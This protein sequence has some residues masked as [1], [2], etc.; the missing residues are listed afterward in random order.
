[1]NVQFYE[2]NTFYKTHSRIW[3]GMVFFC[4]MF[5][6][7][8]QVSPQILPN[9]QATLSPLIEPVIGYIGSIL[10]GSE[11]ENTKLLSDTKA[12]YTFLSVLLLVSIVT[13]LSINKKWLLK[14]STKS[15]YWLIVIFRYYLAYQ[16]FHY[17][18]NKLF[19]WQFFLP[20]PN[21]VYSELGQITPD[22]LYWSAVGSSYGYTVFAGS[23]EIATALLLLFKRTYKIGALAAIVIFSNV[24]LVNFTFNI[25]VKVF[26]SFLLVLSIL[27]FSPS[28]KPLVNLLTFKA[29]EQPTFN[30]TTTNVNPWVYRATK[31]IV[32]LLF[33]AD[34]LWIY[35]KSKNWNDDQFPRISIHGAYEVITS[36]NTDIQ[37]VFINRKGYLVMEDLETNRTDF[38]ISVD[39][40]SR[41]FEMH[42][43]DSTSIWMYEWSED[44][45]LLLKS[46]KPLQ[47]YKLRK[48]PYRNL[49]IFKDTFNWWID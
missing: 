25:S 24:V 41:V 3:I 44:K 27:L 48:L 36:S 11:L 8:F 42:R 30:K 28:F 18:F 16:L 31:G 21:T 20:E 38:Q 14:I 47:Y 40:V 34:S 49:P 4:I 43:L 7:F 26:S 23:I 37:R 45:T 29:I 15:N 12:L 6:T 35:G 17:G 2:Y 9:V 39:T 33:F 10:F 32:V 5:M 19:K 13:A 1:M 46:Y 22:L